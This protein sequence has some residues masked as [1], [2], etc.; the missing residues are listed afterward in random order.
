MVEHEEGG[1]VAELGGTDGAA[2]AGTG[3]FGLGEGL[4]DFLDG[5]GGGHVGGW[6]CG[7]EGA[8]EEGGGCF[9]EGGAQGGGLGEEVGG[10]DGEKEGDELENCCSCGGRFGSCDFGFGGCWFA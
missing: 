4:D 8:S 9:G 7:C 3:A 5:P 1:E 2:D 6:G 10:Q